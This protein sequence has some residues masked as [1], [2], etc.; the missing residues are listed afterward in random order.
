VEASGY[1]LMFC[2]D[3]TTQGPVFSADPKH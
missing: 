1:T 3:F 2:V